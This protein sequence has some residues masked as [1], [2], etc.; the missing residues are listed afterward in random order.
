MARTRRTF[1]PEERLSLLK[2]AERDGS[3]E[4]CRKHS[5]SP[6]LLATWKKKYLAKGADGLKPSY[7]RVDPEVKALQEE[8]DRLKRIVAR[9]AMELEVKTEMLK[10]TPIQFKKSARS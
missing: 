3:T 1:S 2:E 5:L 6:N 4:T 8:N 7:R 10:K 9:Q